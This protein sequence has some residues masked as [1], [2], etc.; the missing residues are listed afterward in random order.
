MYVR[1]YFQNNWVDGYEE[2]NERNGLATEIYILF[3][4]LENQKLIKHQMNLKN[5]LTYVPIWYPL[6]TEL[7]FPTPNLEFCKLFVVDPEPDAIPKINCT[8]EIKTLAVSKSIAH[9]FMQ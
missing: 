5:V 6:M 2:E 9:Q 3:I 8:N 1:I 4:L 7:T